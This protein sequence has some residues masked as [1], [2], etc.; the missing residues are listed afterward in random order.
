[1][2]PTYL[3]DINFDVQ[4][5]NSDELLL[6]SF[7]ILI[8]TTP[9][10]SGE[11]LFILL[12]NLQSAYRNNPYHD[13]THA[14]CVLQFS[15]FLLNQTEIANVLSGNKDMPM[16]KIQFLLLFA[17]IGHD[18]GHD[19]LTNAIHRKVENDPLVSKYGTKSML[20]LLHGEIVEDLSKHFFTDIFAEGKRM[21]GLCKELILSTDMELHKEVC[22]GLKREPTSLMR[23]LSILIKISDISN[24]MR[25][26]SQS[27][28]WAERL[29][30][31]F[32]THPPSGNSPMSMGKS[33]TWFANTFALPLVDVLVVGGMPV[34]AKLLRGQ[35]ERNL[36]MWDKHESE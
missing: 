33:V 3:Q 5:F 2:T 14:V 27:L 28:H 21:M 22:E 30:R 8:N 19:G 18:T 12:T 23:I 17:S 26:F 1:M 36:Q 31:E 35:I 20:E 11:E 25:N 13:F 4:E 29:E 9:S 32:G 24:V 16:G 6:A 10:T 7:L 15:N 34:M